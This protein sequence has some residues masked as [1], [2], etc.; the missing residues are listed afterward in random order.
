LRAFGTPRRH[1]FP[2][3][4]FG[5]QVR[6]RPFE[7]SAAV[8]RLPADGAISHAISP[9]VL[10]RDALA[11]RSL[12]VADLL[13][14]TFAVI[15]GFAVVGHDKLSAAALATLPFV[16]VLSKVIGLYDRD[17]R[18]LHKTTLDEAP[19]L[20]QV[21]TLYTLLMWFGEGI[22]FKGTLGQ[23]QAAGT[24]ILLFLSLM[25]A[26]VV[27]RRAVKSASAPERCLVVGD[28]VSAARVRR[29]IELSLSVRAVL[30]GRLPLGD[31]P[32]MDGVPLLGTMDSLA[33]VV[34]KHDIHRVIVAPGASDG[35]QMLDAIRVVKALGVKVSVLPRL[36]EVVGSSVE[37]DD[38]DGLTLL[39]TPTYGLT[40]S[41]KALKRTFDLVVSAVALVLLAPVFAIFALAIKLTSPGPVI[42]RQ[43]RVGYADKHFEML[44]FRTMHV[45]AHAL[46]AELRSM[47]EAVEGLF[48]IRDDPRI[49][50]VGRF[51]RRSVLDE[52]PQLINVLRGEMSLVGPRPLVPD[53]DCRLA[54]WQRRRLDLKPGMTGIW[55][56]LGGST[57]IP[58]DEMVKLDYLYVANWSL[59]T[60]IKTM[61]RTLP[62][63]VARR[64]L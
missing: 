21:A 60:D 18:L 43:T 13:A 58:L 6:L 9:K 41:S 10:R 4:S 38:L 46:R 23:Q 42:F 55:Q 11:R 32:S 22:W 8:S 12:A 15:A 35:D 1:R 3:L 54:G 37:F 29:K 39:G 24:W 19:A 36:L 26:R 47:N 17:E 49:T 51:L 56:I 62:H 28:A 30:V 7:A 61:V 64:G 57:R 31:D 40:R 34:A 2:I 5:R 48:K 44:K 53:E 25:G 16:L 63:V 20:F 33:T 50:P 45:G 59:W 52:L 14:T 27:A